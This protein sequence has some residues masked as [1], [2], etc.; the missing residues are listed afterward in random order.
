MHGQKL[1]A[2]FALLLP[3]V[4]LL[5]AATA[6]EAARPAEGR[7]LALS[8]AD[9]LRLAEDFTRRGSSVEAGNILVLLSNDPDPQVRNEARYRRALLLEKGGGL[10]GA[11]LLLRQVL[12]QSPDA[13]AVRLKLATL[14]HKM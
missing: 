5:P 4:A 12:D 10:G 8:A 9:L 6:A 14:L 3:A 13:A 11:E 1:R 2:A 7:K